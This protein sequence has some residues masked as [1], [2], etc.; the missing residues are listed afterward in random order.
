[1]AALAALPPGPL[2]KRMDLSSESETAK[3]C[4]LLAVLGLL[5]ASEVRKCARDAV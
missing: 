4:Q 1:M 5:A 3:G 2:T